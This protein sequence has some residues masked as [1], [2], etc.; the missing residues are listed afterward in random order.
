MSRATG[1]LLELGLL[2]RINRGPGRPSEYRITSKLIELTERA[3]TPETQRARIEHTPQA[4]QEIAGKGSR[5]Q[6]TGVARS[7]RAGVRPPPGVRHPA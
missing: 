2:D 3:E 7:S 1:R 6:N 4:E 5:A